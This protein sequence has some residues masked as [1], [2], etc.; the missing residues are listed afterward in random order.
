MFFF[1]S[2]TVRLNFRLLQLNS[3]EM[4]CHGSDLYEGNSTQSSCDTQCHP[5]FTQDCGQHS[6][7][8]AALTANAPVNERRHTTTKDTKKSVIT[9]V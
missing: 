2:V 9:A 8:P 7:S 5:V 3:T 4:G 6:D 1:K